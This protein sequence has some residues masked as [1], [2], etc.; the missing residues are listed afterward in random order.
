VVVVVVVAANEAKPY[1]IRAPTAKI[2]MIEMSKRDRLL[3]NER[4]L[5]VG[6]IPNSIF[7]ISPPTMA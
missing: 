6:V 2:A 7:L 5:G 3:G 4:M 1:A